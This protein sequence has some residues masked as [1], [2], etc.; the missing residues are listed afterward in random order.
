MAL[1]IATALLMLV[2]GLPGCL[3]V[4]QGTS[5]ELDPGARPPDPQPALVVGIREP[6]IALDAPLFDGAE[7]QVWTSTSEGQRS[8][9]LIRAL[10]ASNRFRLVDFEQQLPCPPDLVIMTVENPD[11]FHPDADTAMVFLY[12]GI[13]P[14]IWESDHGHFFVRID[15]PDDL[16]AFPM[17]RTEIVWWFSPLFWPFSGWQRKVDNN[18]GLEEFSLFLGENWARLIK[19]TSPEAPACDES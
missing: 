3:A 19:G 1:R 9:L 17:K 6:P 8:L 4:Y 10:R 2:I 12:L 15:A 16:F 18:I 13:I 11:A 14:A 5:L 7:P